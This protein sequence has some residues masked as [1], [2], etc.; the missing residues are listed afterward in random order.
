MRLLDRYFLRELLVPLGYCLGGFVIFWLA[1]SLVSELDDLQDDKL[2]A[3]DIVEYYAIKL[4]E[5][6]PTGLPV[7]LLLALLFALTNHVRNNEIT[8]ARAAG[9]GIWRLAMPYFAVGILSSLALF[10]M[11]EFWV[12]DSAERAERIR[13][14]HSTT[15]KAPATRHVEENLIFINSRDRR[16]WH[17][18]TY[19][20]RTGEMLNAQV[21][22]IIADGSRYWLYARRVVWTNGVWTFFEVKRYRDTVKS[23]APPVPT[24]ATNLV[25]MAEFTETP[26][27][28]DAAIKMGKRLSLKGGGSPDIPLDEIISYLRFNPNPRGDIRSLLY[29]KLHGRLSTPW[30]C[31]VFVLVALP[32]G[33]ASGRRNV[34]AGVAGSILLC[35]VYFVLLQTGQGLGVAGKVAPWFGA[36]FPNIAFAIVGAVM[37]SRMR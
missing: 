36:W 10:A 25:R 8:A 21:N 13:E 30:A 2:R 4:P 3:A 14:R 23:S 9:I 26:R 20:R 15:A 16:E 32:F 11:N 7:A 37:T 1:F 19:N 28:I 18:A 33:A 17:A 22:W 6:L 29:T 34:F 24:G 12:A 35:F 27:E 31:F 5:F